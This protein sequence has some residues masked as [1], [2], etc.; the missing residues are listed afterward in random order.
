MGDVEHTH[1][2]A[3]SGNGGGV[4]TEV[5]CRRA[6]ASLYAKSSRWARSES[7]L[8]IC[9]KEPCVRMHEE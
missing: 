1:T 7:Q 8:G 5:P 2:H 4:M 3:Q 6:E 9:L